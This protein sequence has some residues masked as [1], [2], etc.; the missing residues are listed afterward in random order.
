M[1]LSAIAF[2]ICDLSVTRFIRKINTEMNA[3]RAPGRNAGD[4]LRNYLR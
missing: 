2:N 3:A 4:C 1:S